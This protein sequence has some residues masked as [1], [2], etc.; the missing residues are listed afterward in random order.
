MLGLADQVRSDL[1]GHGGVVGQDADLGG[2]GLGVDADHPLEKALRGGDVD[3]AGPGDDVDGRHDQG[4]V[5]VTGAVGQHGD[6]LGAAHGVDLLHPEQL[7]GGHDRRV[8]QTVEVLLRGAGDDDLL[9]PGLL[10]G[11][12][13]HHDAAG[14]DGEAARHVQPHPLHGDPALGHAAAGHDLHAGVGAPLVGVHQPGP[15]DRLLQRGPDGRVQRGEGVDQRLG[16]DPGVGQ[17]DA[18]E[19]LRGVQDRR[20]PTGADVVADRPDD[21]EGAL[22]VQHGTRHDTPQL[23]VLQVTSPQVERADERV[24]LLG[25]A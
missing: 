10:R 16:R 14:V 20:D 6:G 12:D 11:H 2:A 9:D 3:V 4:P 21:G 8:G 13:V 5:V 23:A 15:A 7:A 24:D 17:P 25:R 1:G 18:V 19:P 22:D